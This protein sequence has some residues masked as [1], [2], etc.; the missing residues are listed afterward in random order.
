MRVFSRDFYERDT[1]TVARELLGDVLVHRG[2]EGTTS[3]RI[4]ETEAYYGKGDPASRAS[5]KRTKL[6]WLM[7]DRGGLA[8]V[9][10][11]HA[12]WMF[13]VTTEREGV[14]GAAL[15][16]AL[17]PLEGVELMKQRRGTA[18]EQNLTS[19]P[20]K[21]TQAM[22]IT[23]E[24]HGLDLTI[25]KSDLVIVEGESRPTEIA[26]SHRI[27]VSVD[28]KREL[29]F[30]IPGGPHVSIGSKKRGKS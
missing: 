2:R 28:L 30:Y 15:I 21:L 18:D 20:G 7:W 10:M 6:N 11:I 26:S 27:G 25:P 16:R 24:H 12:R 5:R 8:F 4:V 17:E 23:Y 14:P 3:G 1:A 9:Y 22:G 29:R 13:N 19:G